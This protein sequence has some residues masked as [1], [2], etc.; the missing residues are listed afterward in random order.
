MKLELLTR[1]TFR[2]KVFSR[3]EN[4]CVV[5]KA[6]AQ[7]AHHVMERR[8]FGDG[9]Y[10][11]DNGVS[12]CG[13]CH[14]EAE[15]TTEGY[16]PDDLRQ[17]AGITKVILPDHMYPDYIY[18]KWGN[19]INNDGTR[20]RGELFSDESVQKVLA[21]GKVLSKFLPYVKYPRTYHL[22]FS[23]GRTPDDKTLKNCDIFKFGHVVATVKMDGE[24]T[25]GY[26]DGHVHARSVDSRNH[27]SRNWVKQ[28]LAERLYELPEGW[29]ICGENLYAKHSIE[30]KNLGS[31]FY[32][33]SI[34]NDKNVC[35]TWSDTLTWA[36]LLD[37]KVV[38]VLLQGIFDENE[39]Q[40]LHKPVCE[41]NECEGFVVRHAYSFGYA[42]Y[43]HHVAKYVRADHVQTNQ[44]WLRG[45][46]VRNGL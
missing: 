33:F 31:Y 32:L 13:T 3:D 19:V 39:I 7:D 41:D 27:A 1:D 29:R 43:R 36:G 9:G 10:Y 14:L 4:L 16:H 24:N 18:D 8:L 44:H 26:W 23:P 20:W 22:P 46:I 15:R 34:W 2:K 25:T 6:P 21:E 12:L 40:K 17:L 11:I 35:L 28:H 45:P 30:Y 5:C 37:L 38:P 42:T